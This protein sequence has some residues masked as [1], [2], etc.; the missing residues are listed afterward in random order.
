[1][2][3]GCGDEDSVELTGIS[4]NLDN[5]RLTVGEIQRIRVAT[6]PENATGVTCTWSSANPDVATVN[7]EGVIHIRGVGKT[8]VTVTSG[9]LSQTVAVEGL[10]KNLVLKELDEE[11]KDMN[12]SGG[13]YP[14]NGADITFTITATTEPVAEVDVEWSSDVD[15]VTVTPVGNGMSATVTISG[16]GNAVITAKTDEREWYYNI[17]T[18]SV[19]ESAVGYWQFDNANN[20][21]EATVGSPLI[22]QGEGFSAIAGPS[23]DN[24]AVRVAKGSYFRAPHG[25]AANGG[26]SRVNIYSVMFD[27]KVSEL[28][29][30]YSFIQTTLGNNDDAEF[31]LRPAG[32]L[33]IGGTGYSEH[34]VTAGEW[35]RLVIS[36]DMGNAYLYYLD[37]ALIHTGNL[38]SASIDSRW[39]WLPEGVL[40]FADEDGEDNEIDVSN[41]AVW[42]VALTSEEI[43]ALG[44]ASK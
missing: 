6:T 17:S 41:I 12:V 9:A 1:M 40:L 32:N 20:I 11:G 3:T 7:E 18:T 24:G 15:N 25:M 42:S 4:I 19:F 34:V 33:G 36:A 39:S 14:Y 16:S 37:G 26:G 10:I 35:H 28:G 43:A 30:Y 27:F 29:R 23:A 8:T 5:V 22:M 21:V 31:F 13:M 38:G 44:G 2:M